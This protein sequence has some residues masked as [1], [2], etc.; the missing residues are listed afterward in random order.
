MLTDREQ[1]IYEEVKRSMT[2]DRDTAARIL[3]ELI[4]GGSPM[5]AKLARSIYNDIT[6]RSPD[7]EARSDP[8]T[9]AAYSK[10]LLDLHDHLG[11]VYPNFQSKR[12]DWGKVGHEL[13]PRVAQAHT[14]REFGLLVE[15]MVAR[16]EDSHAVVQGGTA[17]PP[18]LDLPRWDPGLA[19]LIDDRGR[20]V[21]YSVDPGSP[22]EKAEIRPGMTVVSINGVTSEE[23][24]AMSGRAS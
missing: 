12:I 18:A 23:A 21:V 13:I 17:E 24:I 8:A 11:R 5:Q 19:S 4:R 2:D 3:D 1:Q 10:A 22:A 15:E 6:G 7:G 9:E 20:M 14:Q 16:L